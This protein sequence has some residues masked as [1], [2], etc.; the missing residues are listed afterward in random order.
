MTNVADP[1]VLTDHPCFSPGA[2]AR[3]GR[4]HLPVAPR[5]NVRCR[6]CTRKHDC[7]NESRPGVTSRVLTP[8]EAVERA[9][10]VIE[11]SGAIGAVGIA[12]PGDPLA[13]EATFETFAALRR[14]HPEVVLCASTNGLALPERVGDLVSAGVSS[15]TVTINAV[16]PE[17]AAALYAWVRLDG[18]RHVGLEAGEAI[19]A[20]Q[21]EGLRRA[22]SAGL[23]CKVNS[24]LVPGF[25]DLEI[26][27]IAKLAAEAGAFIHN[28]TPLIPNAGFA[29]LTA[30]TPLEIHELRAR[31]GTYLSQMTHCRQCRADA[32][33]RLGEDGDMESE[34]LMA[35]LGDDYEMVG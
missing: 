35:H 4:I 25:N 7:V 26:E 3:R 21:W 20:R 28:V 23:V 12:G 5:C 13:N 16:M 31:C 17:T 14:L 30:P 2:H 11:R 6:Y 22:T 24:V 34:A 18:V 10:A 27:V 8:A 15:L 29:H 1:R 9:S 32:C 33:G 19:L